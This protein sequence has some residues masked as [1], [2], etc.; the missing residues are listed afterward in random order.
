M[1][2]LYTVPSIVGLNWLGRRGSASLS[3]LLCGGTMAVVPWLTPGTAAATVLFMVARFFAT[4]AMNVGF[5]I[6]VEVKLKAGLH[7]PSTLV[8][9]VVTA[10]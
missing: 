10:R 6:C 1:C 8:L 3:L 4:Y 5:Q 9:T 7:N 2:D